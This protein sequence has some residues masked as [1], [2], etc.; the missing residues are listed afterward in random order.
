MITNSILCTLAAGIG[1]AI[2]LTGLGVALRASA[3]LQPGQGCQPV[4]PPTNASLCAMAVQAGDTGNILQDIG[5]ISAGVIVS[6]RGTKRDYRM[7]IANWFQTLPRLRTSMR[8]V[9]V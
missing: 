9:L 1:L 7:L 8:Y 6:F 4:D 3:Q 5:F 2:G